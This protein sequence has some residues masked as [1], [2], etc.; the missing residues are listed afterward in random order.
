MSSGSE[1]QT[2]GPER[3]VLVRG[4]VWSPRWADL[5]W[6]LVPTSR[7]GLQVQLGMSNLDHG[8][9][10]RRR[11]RS[12]S[13][14]ADG[15][16]ANGADPSAQWYDQTSFCSRSAWLPHWEQIAVFARQCLWH[17]EKCCC[18]NRRDLIWE[19]G[20]MIS[21]HPWW[22]IVEWISAFSTDRNSCCWHAGLF[23]VHRQMSRQDSWRKLRIQWSVH[24]SLWSSCRSSP[25]AVWIQATRIIGVQFQPI[26][27]HSS[28]AC[29]QVF[30]TGEAKIFWLFL[31]MPTLWVRPV[32]WP[33]STR[34]V[35]QR[36]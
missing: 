30:L 20:Q 3:W 18:N 36:H 4:T 14:Y 29:M 32:Y 21:R 9:C 27:L 10:C 33:D 22:V 26:Q 1:F 12:W 23:P 35:V 5:K 16:E 11:P 24:I 28:Q 25:T 31:L 17:R 2:T 13:R 19:N 7:T 6:A 15:W 34:Q 8:G